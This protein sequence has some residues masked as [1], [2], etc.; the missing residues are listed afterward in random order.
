[1]MHLYQISG[2]ESAIGR[3]ECVV[4][5]TNANVGSQITSANDNFVL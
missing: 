2:L 3:S 1:M 4:Y 5:W